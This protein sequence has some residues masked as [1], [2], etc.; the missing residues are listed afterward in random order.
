MF[1]LE[2][3][4]GFEPVTRTWQ[5]LVLPTTPHPHFVLVYLFGA[6]LLR[7]RQAIAGIRTRTQ[8]LEDSSATVTPQSRG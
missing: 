3:K 2:Q 5:A 6:I 7:R 1:L 8:S 4:T